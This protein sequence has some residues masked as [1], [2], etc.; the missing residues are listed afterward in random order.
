MEV[1]SKNLDGQE[2]KKEYGRWK[3]GVEGSSMCGEVERKEK[4]RAGSFS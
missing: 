2:R 3:C 4:S 1:G